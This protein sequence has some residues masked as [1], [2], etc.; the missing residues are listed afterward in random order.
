M[1]PPPDPARLSDAEK[2]A[3]ILRQAA[4]IAEQQALI[5]QLT[6]R[7][8]EL[9]AELARLK[10]PGKD[11]SNS[12]MPP[13]R[14]N[15]PNR[16]NRP[17]RRKRG[18]G[19]GGGRPLQPDP[20]ETVQCR[21]VTCP[22][23]GGAMPEAEQKVVR[24]YDRIEL[25][26]P[27]PV[28]TRVE[29]YGGRCRCCGAR[30]MAPAPAGL[31][32]GSPFGP[33]IVAWAVYLRHVHAIGYQRLSRLF[34]DLFG[35]AISE[36]ALANLLHR[37]KPRF[38]DQAAAILARLRR[39]RL[40]CSDETGARLRGRSVWEWVFQNDHY[41]VH[42]IRDSRAQT[43]P[44]AVMAGHRPAIWVSDLY[45]AQQGH[46][47]QWQV[48]LAHQLRDC[49]YAIDA[50]DAVFA[51]AMKHLLLRACAIGRR[52]PDLKDSTLR[53]YRGDLE[54]RLDRIMALTP[55]SADGKRLRK[56][57]A[58]CRDALFL[59][60]TERDVPATNNASERDIRPSTTFR[61][62]TG[63]F[64]SEWGADLYAGVRST[65]NT[66]RR[67]GLSPL[68]AIQNTLARQPVWTG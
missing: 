63:G 28:V 55:D 1:T 59:F 35:L 23:C 40:V 45:G 12:G 61:K 30:V 54:R 21:L 66:A 25:P 52:R 51:P 49:Q 56:R 4:L 33:G 65:L 50:G 8:A 62:V 7:S 24:R 14:D 67:Q 13:S 41:C 58:A 5:A 22:G 9:E 37:A 3:L 47:A 27:R 57:Y 18:R 36:G 15:K 29:L 6:A 43:V 32:P 10:R 60:V 38:D 31:E 19:K 39:S 64:R 17:P 42:V 46:A 2:D 53:Q 44:K 26:P 48:C 11:S 16:P 20:D 68:Q 34:A